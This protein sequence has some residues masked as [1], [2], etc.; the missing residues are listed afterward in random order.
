MVTHYFGALRFFSFC[1]FL[2]YLSLLY[3]FAS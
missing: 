3:V 1:F 2:S